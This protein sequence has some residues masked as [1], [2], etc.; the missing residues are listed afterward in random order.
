MK[1]SY[2]TNLT[3]NN[4][5]GGWSGMN[6]HVYK[7][8]EKRAEVQLIQGI[9]PPYSFREKLQSKLFRIAGLKGIYPAFTNHRLDAIRS[10]VHPKIAAESQLLFFH[11]VTPWLHVNPSVPYSLYLDACFYSYITIYHTK[12]EF[13]T[14]QLEELFK[15]EAL[16]LQNAKAVFFSSAWA[17]EETKKNYNLTGSNFFNAGLGGGFNSQSISEEKNE[18]DPPY[19][20][21]VGHDFLGKGGDKII[22]AFVEIQKEF[23][24]YR[25][26]II[27]QP[28]PDQFLIHSNVEYMGVI[29]KSLP[30]ALDKMINIFANAYC[31]L[32]PTSKDITPL[33]LV[34]AGSVGCPAIATDNFG[35]PEIVVDGETGILIK[36][37]EFI[38]QNLTG[39]M[40]QLCQNRI[41]RNKMSGKAKEH[42]AKKFS[43]DITGERIDKILLQSQS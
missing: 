32:L 33:V 21:F 25:L 20:L 18:S 9:N 12:N 40:R 26:K 23:P 2:I 30:G 29:D 17:L 35:I 15:K 14:S 22:S 37:D 11:G 41:L 43:W 31:F 5:S 7:E 6:Y 1:I 13:S 4:S 34:E 3:V 8:L 42:I 38:E 36:P 28:P 16:F 39:A 10:L 27:G 19:F 24:E